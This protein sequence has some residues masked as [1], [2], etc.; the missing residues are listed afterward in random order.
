[1]LPGL[2]FPSYKMGAP[3]PPP[4]PR[5][6]RFSGPDLAHS[7]ALDLKGF[8]FCFPEGPP[9]HPPLPPRP[10]PP[11]P[12]HSS[13]G[14]SACW[15]HLWAC[16]L[17]QHGPDRSPRLC[18][19]STSSRKPSSLPPKKPGHKL[20]LTVL[21]VHPDQTLSLPSRTWKIAGMVFS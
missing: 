12:M 5:Q 15:P 11:L 1:M 7:Q 8:P 2:S 9:P 17:T 16:P 3:P 13:P 21:T 20:L 19:N 10:G 4:L 18:P 6:A 14:K